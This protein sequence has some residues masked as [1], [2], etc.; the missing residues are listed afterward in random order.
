MTKVGIYQEALACGGTLKVGLDRW[1]IS[2][3]FAGP[4]LRHKG[5]FF[6]IYDT[7]VAEY[8]EAFKENWIEYQSLQVSIP[9]GGDFSKSGKKGMMIRISNFN[10]GICLHS[11]HMPINSAEKLKA[12]VESYEYASMRA[13][14]I[15]TLLRTL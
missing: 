11:Y 9:K 4:D 1:E 3:Y 15:Q 14:Q 7:Q 12:I 5:M 8:I 13:P 2:Y 6:S 10:P